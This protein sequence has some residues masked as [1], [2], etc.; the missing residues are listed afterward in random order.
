[1]IGRLILE[2]ATGAAVRLRS[3]GSGDLEDLRR[4][5]NDHREAF[6][7]KEEITPQGQRRWFEGYLE[8]SEDCMF[9]VEAGAARAGCLGFRMEEGGAADCYNIIASPAGRGKGLLKAGMGL[10][11]SY[12][13]AERTREICLKVLADNPAAGFYESCGYRIVATKDGVHQMRLS[14]NFLPVPYK[15]QSS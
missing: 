9:V 6:F 5:K 15:I 7:F 4:W 3:I 8:R 1:M 14:G 12:L 2:P 11:C 10:M 13:L